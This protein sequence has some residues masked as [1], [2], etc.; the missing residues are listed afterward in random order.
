MTDGPERVDLETPDL[1][2]EKRAELAAMFPGVITDGVL[3]AAKL[4]E[5]L[6]C[7]VAQMPEGR[8]RY[9]LQWAGRQDAV[10]SLLLPGQGALVPDLEH[11]IDFD[12]ARHIFIEGDNLEVLKLLQKAYNDRVN[13]IYIDPPYNTGNDFVYNDDFSDG[14]RSYLAFTGQVDEDGLRVSTKQDTS[15]R[16]HSKWLSMMLPRLVLARNLLSQDGVIFVSIDDN[17]VAQLRLLLDE[18]FGPENF[19]A[20][21]IWEKRQNRENRKEVSYRHDTI[22]CYARSADEARRLH[23]L[24]MSAK[25]LANYRNPDSDPRGPWKSDPATGQAGHG[26]AAQ[27]Y[28]VTAPNGKKHNL[29]SGRCWIYSKD[30]MERAIAEGRMWF[31]ADGNGVPRVKT[32]LEAKDRGLVPETI[33][34][35]ADVGTNESAKNDLKNLFGGIAAF[36]TPKPVALL[37]T[38]AQIGS[39]A[40]SLILDF[41]AGSGT[42]GEAVLRLNAEDGGTRRVIQVQLPEVLPSD[43]E[44]RRLGHDTVSDV[45]RDRWS[46]VAETLPSSVDISLRS[47]VLDRSNFVV[48]DHED[49]QL[50]LTVSTLRNDADDV[51]AI[52]SEVLL[53]EGVLLD[54]PW[55]EHLFGDVVIEMSGGVAVVIGEDLDE[56]IVQ[57]VFDLSPRVVVFMEDDLAGKDAIK[58][59]AFTGARN[60]NITMKTV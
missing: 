14:L 45:A 5:L 17:E 6:D 26:T 58:A 13:L 7:A 39:N 37:Q 33:L 55:T 56:A 44:A 27:F 22:I 46:R 12:E 42:M 11:S 38:L 60:Q 21:F 50:V 40:D 35:A 49:G 53:K 41:F 24:P 25:A 16:K 8:E 20:T 23:Q 30:A 36:D 59:N 2:A 1:A 48:Q 9:G 19:I 47:L 10:R 34:F 57:N 28:V 15:G 3:D 18:V 31:G 54:A 32:Y 29:P 52:A 51:W 43:S 4:G